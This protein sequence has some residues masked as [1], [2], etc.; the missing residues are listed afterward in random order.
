MDGAPPDGNP[1]DNLPLEILKNIQEHL[2]HNDQ[3]AMTRTERRFYEVFEVP[4]YMEWVRQAQELLANPPNNPQLIREHMKL[5]PRLVANI[6]RRELFS[7][8]HR[9]KWS[10]HIRSLLIQLWAKLKENYTVNVG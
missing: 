10:D 4:G 3:V 1:F 2:P 8:T 9:F 5:A 6:H 7:Q